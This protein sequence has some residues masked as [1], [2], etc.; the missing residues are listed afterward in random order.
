M[1][2]GLVKYDA[3]C[4]ALAEARAVDEAKKIRDVAMALKVYAKQAKNKQLEIDA[5]EIRFRAER[6]VGELI[7]AQRESVGLNVGSRLVGPSRTRQ[8]EKP[9]LAEAG[10]DKH[11]ADRARK[12]AAV[13]RDEFEAE[14]ANWRGRVSRENE[15]VTANLL[16]KGARELEREEDEDV[17]E[18]IEPEHFEGAFLIRAETAANFAVYARGPVTRDV[19]SFARKA[20]KAW[21]ALADRLEGHF[22]TR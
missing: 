17:E 6:R 11:L 22:R 16:A 21:T 13:S 10:I 8:D 2:F 15:R 3:A 14:V 4:R 12:M 7:A 20:A 1:S 18:D 19:V 5:A 9:T